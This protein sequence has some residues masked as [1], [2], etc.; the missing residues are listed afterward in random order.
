MAVHNWSEIPPVYLTNSIYRNWDKDT[1]GNRQRYSRSHR[2]NVS[3]FNI[4]THSN[5]HW[6]NV[7][8][9]SR[10][11]RAKMKQQY[12]EF[13]LMSV[14]DSHPKT[15]LWALWGFQGC[16][17]ENVG[18]ECMTVNAT[19]GFVSLL[20]VCVCVCVCVC[21]YVCLILCEAPSALQQLYAT[22]LQSPAAPVN[23]KNM[24]IWDRNTEH[25]D[26]DHNFKSWNILY[27]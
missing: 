16:S 27:I 21:M 3:L 24:R 25:V 10:Q 8:A 7:A 17:M 18:A 12:V 14:I 26:L 1:S 22:L 2:K 15:F 23:R 5:E 11:F 6:E 9:F 4:Q 19:K 20:C 13:L